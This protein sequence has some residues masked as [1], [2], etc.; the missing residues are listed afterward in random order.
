MATQ[1]LE[2]TLEQLEAL[3]NE[4]VRAQSIRHGAGD[5]QYGV[6]LGDIRIVAKG[7]KLSSR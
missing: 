7:R 5:N 3:G 1:T 2:A 4:K 6:R